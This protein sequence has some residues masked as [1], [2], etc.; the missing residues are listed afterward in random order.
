MMACGPL[1]NK[2]EALG[3][4]SRPRAGARS[5]LRMRT[6]ELVSSKIAWTRIRRAGGLARTC[7]RTTA[8]HNA[9]CLLRAYGPRP[10][11][12]EVWGHSSAVR[13]A[14]CVQS[15]PLAQSESPALQHA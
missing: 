15:E 8:Q 5:L 10:P 6:E 12:S 9:V 13:F 4:A 11:T 2:P 3:S 7:Q 1:R 14:L